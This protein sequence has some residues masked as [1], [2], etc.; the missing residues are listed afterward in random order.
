MIG[1]VF[2]LAGGALLIWTGIRQWRLRKSDAIS[3]I[4]AG[5]LKATKSEPLPRTVYDRKTQPVFAVLN[6][7]FGAFFLIIGILFVA[8]EAGIL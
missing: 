2:Y 3:L 8:S 6:L 5:L 4:E 7:I 1:A